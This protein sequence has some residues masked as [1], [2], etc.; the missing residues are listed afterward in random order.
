MA[1]DPW[2]CAE[3][4]NE[5]VAACPDARVT[6]LLIRDDY[7]ELPLWRAR[8]SGQRMRGYDSDVQ[9]VLEQPA[10]APVLFPR[11]LLLTALVRLCMCD[12]FVH[13]TGGARYDVVMERWIKSWLGVDPAP[14]AV[15]SATMRLPL[16]DDGPVPEPDDVVA[17]SRRSRR[18]WH[19]PESSVDDAAGRG[20]GAEKRQLLADIEAAPVGSV[21]RRARFLA[22]HDELEKLRYRHDK[23]VQG[24]KRAADDLVRRYRERPIVESREWPFPLYD[25]A[26]LDELAAELVRTCD[27]T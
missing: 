15:V 25:P 11:A 1:D 21:E 13:G 3:A 19:D 6:P 9:R 18:A 4:Y 10:R 5:A 20:P 12:L 8:E 2:T 24:A 17:A 16:A 23:Q 7:V 27:A 26:A 14:I 22:M